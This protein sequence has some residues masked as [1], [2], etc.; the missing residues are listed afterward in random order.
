MPGGPV[1]FVAVGSRGDVE[2]L[3]ILAGAVA[4]GGRAATV[5]AIDEYADRVGSPASMLRDD[6]AVAQIRAGRAQQQ[7][8]AQLA[9]MA[10]PIA[11]AAGAMR[12]LAETVPQEGSAAESMA[13]AL[14]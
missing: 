13:G 6:D 4:A 5:V 9:Q 14:G 11:D 12:T 3:A 7:Q 10:K 8:M 2:P 1:T